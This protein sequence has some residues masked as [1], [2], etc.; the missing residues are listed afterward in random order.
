MKKRDRV[1][2]Y[3]KQKIEQQDIDA[4]ISV[5]NSDFLTQG[6]QVSIFEEKVA[7]HHN[8]KY[9]VAFCNGTAALHAAY[10]A[11]GVTFGDEIITSP[12][13]FAATANAAI[14]CGAKPLFVDIDLETNCIDVNRIEEKITPK[15]K[16]ITPVSLAG[17]PVNLKEIKQIADKHECFVIHDAAHA[18]GSKR[19]GS[20]G[21]ECADMAILSFHPVKHITTAEGGMVLTNSKELYQKLTLFRTHGITKNPE[22]M[23]HNEG[24]WYYEMKSLG[25]NYRLSDVHA[26][27]GSSQ[28]ERIGENLKRRNEIAKYYNEQLGDLPHFII[29]PDMGFS[30]LD[31]DN[32]PNIHSYHL[33]TLRLADEK[34]RLELYTYLHE[35]GILAQI[36]YIPL[37]WQPYYQGRFG[38]KKGDFPKAEIYYSSE[39]SIPM[40]HGM[41]DADVE[42]VVERIK[43]VSR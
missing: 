42:Y 30:I 22:V 11:A 23:N 41:E 10:S 37:H 20:F 31:S 36:H 2:P 13:T 9:A 32:A 18:I 5:L 24:P 14:Y 19:E 39:I 12:I 7:E 29:P 40:Y 1:I 15:T 28:F 4:V 6:P 8:A 34:K 38:Y 17:Y 21:M 27:L 26:A 3:G 43:N 25:W 35:N 16:V 33:Y